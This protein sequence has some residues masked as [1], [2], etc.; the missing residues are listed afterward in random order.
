LKS[1]KTGGEARSLLQ[2]EGVIEEIQA[3]FLL[4]FMKLAHTKGAH[5]KISNET[6]TTSHRYAC[7]SLGII[8]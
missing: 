4:S 8:S 7:L 5:P 1:N 6:E 2:K 3:N